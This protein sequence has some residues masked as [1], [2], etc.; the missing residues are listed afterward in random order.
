MTSCT[1]PSRQQ[2]AV[3]LISVVL[4]LI[5][6][7]AVTLYTGRVK[8]LEQK[9][10]LNEQNYRI[11]FSA[12]EAGL[13]RVLGLLS[14]EPAWNGAA[15][16]DD[17]DTNATYTVSGVRQEVPRQ[18]STVTVVSLT[19]QGQSPDGLGTVTIQEQALL[20]SVLANPPDAPLIVAGGLNVGGNFEVTANPNGGG[21]GVPLSIWTDMAVDMN[22][23]SGTT[24]GLHESQTGTCSSDA[25]SEKGFKGLDIVDDDPGF[26]PD[27][28]EYLFN[29]PEAEWP[30]LRADADLRLNSCAGL[31]PASV[32]LIWVDGNCSVN[33]NTIIGSL[34]NPVILIVTDGDITM[35]G[36]AELNGILFS[37]RKPTTVNPFEINMIGGARVNGVVAS[38]HPVGHANGTYNAVYDADV[39][40]SIE[41]HDAFR[42]VGRIPGSWRDF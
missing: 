39:L 25:Y 41:E 30:Q 13:M 12:A 15:V 34:A 33:A 31:G 19:S 40:S 6:V 23:G 20:Y 1:Q 28:M 29:V 37:F 22:N 11:G 42:R 21:T 4:L 26:P 3:I 8:V 9:V 16:V 24:C 17:L 7:L 2:G 38:N 18:S 35:N 36:G 14:E 10:L 32:G 5:I 27:L